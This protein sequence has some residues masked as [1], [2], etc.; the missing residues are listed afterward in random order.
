MKKALTLI[1]L[2]ILSFIC[3]ELS[4]QNALDF[5]GTDDKVDCGNDTSVQISGKA[6]T[7]EAWIYPT[8]WKTN[9]FDG[10]VINK[11]YNTSNYGYM[12]RVGAGGKLNFAIGDGTWR[13]I[14]TGTIL[15]LNTWQH[16]AGTYD[17]AKMRVY[18]NGA[19]VDSLAVAI[20][21]TKT[22][23][24]NLMLG[25]HSTY[26]RF[27]QG[28]IDEVR[29]WSVCRSVDQ[30]NNN[31][32]IEFCSSQTGLRAYYKFNQGKAASSN[33][34]ISTLADLSDYNNNASLVNFA[35]SGGSSNWVRGQVFSKTVATSTQ[36]ISGCDNYTSPSGKYKWLVSG[37]YLD[38]ISVGFYGCDSIITT[39]LTIKKSTGKT[40]SAFACKSYTSPSGKFVWTKSGNYKDVIKNYVQCDSILSIVLKIG[41]SKDSVLRVVCNTFKSV[42]GKTYTNTG[43]YYDTILNYRG[44]DS[45]VVTN[46][47]VNKTSLNTITAKACKKYTL[48]SG[49][50]SYFVSGTYKDTLKNYKTC[51]SI[52]TI[53]LLIKNSSATVNSAACKKYKSP[54]GKYTWNISGVYKDTILN[55]VGCDSAITINLTILN[56]TFGFT[57][58]NACRYYKR[59]GKKLVYTKSG[60]YKDTLVNHL[61][62]DS[63][64]TFTL[65][66]PQINTT[67]NK[68]GATLTAA[69]L[70]GNYQ[71]MTC[72]L[73]TVVPINGATQKSYTA[74]FNGS[75][76]L[77]TLDSAC[78]DTSVC[79]TV[80]DVVTGL[81]DVSKALQIKII[82][83]PNKGNFK[84]ILPIYCNAATVQLMD[85]SGKVLLTETIENNNEISL[86]TESKFKAGFY[87]IK[88]ESLNY[89]AV[90]RILIEN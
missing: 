81:N 76:A 4:A 26:T 66:L 28:L 73:G 47:K 29:I 24:T 9:A 72:Q 86:N 17:G 61:G 60:T 69:K 59:L 65:T 33:S 68:S 5:D 31:K 51:D 44:C 18:L 38:T 70:T 55:T 63:I 39:N 22:P 6:I 8:A 78:K 53:N 25:A 21:I 20:S 49:K 71:W 3:I 67:I 37:T 16:I 57:A 34:A 84:L 87:L 13:E 43:I 88:V 40:I 79:I 58:I 85:L 75:Y 64:L 15:S 7:L 80:N 52:L 62:C 11:E 46:L 32:G 82:P 23:I 2:F 35:L 12:L 83:N 77:E 74:P 89:N 54:S 45:V 48:P 50:R 1:S 90:Q 10:N 27:Y 36:K 19:A 14:T 56:P 41:G 42:T 30:L